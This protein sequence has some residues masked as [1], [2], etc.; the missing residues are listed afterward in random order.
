VLN[1]GFEFDEAGREELIT[2]VLDTVI[3]GLQT[4]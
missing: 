3:A 1:M 4:L 2:R